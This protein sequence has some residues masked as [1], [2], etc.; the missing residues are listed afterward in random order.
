MHSP[1]SLRRRVPYE[2]EWNDSPAN[3]SKPDYLEWSQLWKQLH[4]YRRPQKHITINLRLH[5]R[6]P[7]R[8]KISH[9]CA[10]I[11]LLRLEN[12]QPSQLEV[13]SRLEFRNFYNKEAQLLIMFMQASPLS[14]M[15]RYLDQDSEV[16]VEAEECWR[17]CY[18]A[19]HPVANCSSTSSAMVG[20]LQN[21]SF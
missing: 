21:R 9:F 6:I 13:A 10:E 18:D 20:I 1:R 5:D 16:K 2:L 15:L 17:R 14:P 8:K 11:L 4:I 7:T 19:A 3:S 12:M